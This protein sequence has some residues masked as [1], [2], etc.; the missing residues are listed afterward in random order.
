MD[1]SYV[2]LFHIGFD[3]LVFNGTVFLILT[4]VNGNCQTKT[5]EYLPFV[6]DGMA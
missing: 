6:K 1:P 2:I 5:G 3:L 4:Q